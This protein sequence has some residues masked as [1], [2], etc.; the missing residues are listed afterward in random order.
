M[1]VVE[2]HVVTDKCTAK[3]DSVMKRQMTLV[4]AALVVGLCVCASGTV[5]HVPSQY[6][7]IQA[8]I[9]AAVDGDTVLVADGTYTGEGNR[10]IDFGGKAIV[11][12]SENGPEV[13][14]IDCEQ[15][16]RGFCLNSDE[17]PS[18]VLQ[19]FTIT[20]GSADEGGAIFCYS[21]ATIV[22]NIISGN[23]GNWAGGGIHCGWDIGSPTIV[24]NVISGNTTPGNGGGIYGDGR[25]CAPMIVGN[26]ITGNT[27]GMDGGGI[28][29]CDD[30]PSLVR[31]NLI[32]DNTAGDRGGG[33]YSAGR[34]S[35]I[36]GNAIIGNAAQRGG[37]VYC[38]GSVTMGNTIAGNVANAGGGLGCACAWYYGPVVVK[39]CIFWG[40][41][42]NTGREI[43]VEDDGSI[44]ISYSDLKGG[45]SSVYVEPGG[46]VQVG[47]GNIVANPLFVAGPHGDY[48]LS[49]V[50]SGQGQDSPCLDAGDPALLVGEGT[51]RTDEVCDLWPLDMGYHYPCTPEPTVLLA[52]VTPDT[53]QIK[54]GEDLWFTVNL[55]N[56][57]DS[58]LTFDAWVDVYLHTA[59]PYPG[60]PV[61][62]PVELTFSAG[63]GIYGLH[64]SLH[65]PSGA[66][67]GWYV[68]CVR[69]GEYPD[70]IWAE[71]CF[72]FAILT[73][74]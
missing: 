72:Y 46:H 16:G 44:A 14:V 51:T 34:G 69:T 43:Y 62:G 30:S 5:L 67:W 29:C 40:D 13:T 68:L 54:A 70:S 24:G 39:S 27:A 53:P 61:V 7:T 32:A 47:Q 52:E 20:N 48:Y 19:G 9:D 22:G 56:T 74:R 25:Y 37:A 66:P 58:T 15:S 35:A 2:I 36:F 45:A 6:A 55:V 31:G 41:S 57:T 73:P 60:N 3:E 4:S 23:T 18:S 21:S 10:N 12:M 63:F 28:D 11:V 65:T 64:R 38:L 42:A 50:A 59:N 8:G 26:V 71:D 49:Q 1:R 17:G 33:V